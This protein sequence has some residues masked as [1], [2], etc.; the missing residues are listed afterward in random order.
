MKNHNL[1][2]LVPIPYMRSAGFAPL[3]CSFFIAICL[4]LIALPLSAQE[5]QNQ[6]EGIDA[7]PLPA[8]EEAIQEETTQEDA[9]QEEAK[10]SGDLWIGLGGGIAMY[11][12]SSVSYGVSIAIAYGSGTSIGLKLSWFFDQG[13]EMNTLEID[14][15][16]RLYFNGK[17]AVSGLFAQFEGGP[18]IY[19]YTN[20][21][22]SFP[23]RI[24]MASL[25]AAVGWHFLLGKYIFLEPSIRAGYP[26]MFGINLLAGVHF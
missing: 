26:Y 18:A 15:L 5:E 4:M 2:N 17:T 21:N 23:A 19:F 16:F 9:S 14:F 11:S 6:P 7:L 22:V 13:Q 25:G 12:P 1:K 8:Q 3:R 24:G 10:Q 20:E